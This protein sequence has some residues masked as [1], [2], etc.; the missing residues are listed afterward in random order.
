MAELILAV[1]Q[2]TTGTTV[3][4]VRPDG[5]VLGRGYREHPQHF[6]QPGWVEHDPEAIWSSVLESTTEAMAAAGVVAGDLAAVGITNQRETIVAW[7][8]A[9]GAA[10]P[11]TIVW[12]DRR[13]AERC[14][15]LRAAGHGTRVRELTGLPVDPYFSGTK[16]EWLL[17]HVPEAR[18]AADAGTLR[19]GTI[20]SWLAWRM[21]AGAAHITDASNAAR[22]MLY[23]IHAGRWSDEL[24]AML[25]VDPAWLPRVVDCAGELARCDGAAYL[26]IDAPISGIAGD[27]QSALFGQACLERGQAKATYGTG[28]FVLVNSGDSA[29]ASEALIST[30]AWQLGGAATYA[31]EGSVFTAGASVQWLRDGVQF[32]ESARD[33]EQLAASVPDSGGVV[34][35]P[36]FAGLGAPH[37]DAEARGA[38]LGL[39]RGTTRA[40]V[41]RATLEA[42]A[43]RVRQLVDSMRAEGTDVHELRV[44]GGMAAND[45]LMQ[46]QAD[47]LGVPVTRPVNVETTSLGAAFLA[48]YGSGLHASLDEVAAAWKVERTFEPRHDDAIQAAFARFEHAVDATRAFARATTISSSSVSPA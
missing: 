33:V 17:Q 7:D 16:V 21:S 30:V 6:P 3:L 35:V 47:V 34:L 43:F 25:G 31:L 40:H 4:V 13:T 45:L 20:D 32:I 41:A 9:T 22:T 24:C 42:V 11:P 15:A 5:S 38:L 44:D 48:A 27:Q 29:P 12:Q 39:T 14:R 18:A 46:L 8:S 26:G 28:A 19:I 2:G 23:D 37:W 10:I 36:A 1:D